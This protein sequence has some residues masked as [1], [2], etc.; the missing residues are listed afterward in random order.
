MNL[1]VTISKMKFAHICKAWWKRIAHNKKEK[2]ANEIGQ[3]RRKLAFNLTEGTFC[4]S[5]KLSNLAHRF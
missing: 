4:Q 5:L 2:K 1:L 3:S